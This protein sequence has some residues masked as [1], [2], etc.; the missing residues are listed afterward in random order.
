MTRITLDAAMLAK[1]HNLTEPL[2]VC[3][4]SGAVLARLLPVFDPSQYEPLEPQ[5]SQEELRRRAQSGEK[6]YTT[7][8][9]LAYLEKL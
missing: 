6:T 5:V 1:L 8:E 7:A 4:E 9:V 3:D 2:E